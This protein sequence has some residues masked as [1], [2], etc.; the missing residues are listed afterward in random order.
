MTQ[1][2]ILVVDDEPFN[3][4]ILREYLEDNGY[5]VISAD[6]GDKALDI[7]ESNQHDFDA[8]LL[9]RMMPNMNG[10]EV[11]KTLKKSDTHK[12]LPVIMQTAAA[13]NKE[14]IQGIEAGA[15]YYLTK[16]YEPEILISIVNSAVNDYN[17]IKN[18]ASSTSTFETGSHLIETI[19]FTLQTLTEVDHVVAMLSKIIPSQ[20]RMVLGLTE[21]L[22]NAIEH[23]N[24]AIGYDLKTKLLNNK[25]WRSEI[26]K[27]LSQEMYKHKHVR[28]HCEF[29]SK[30]LKISIT[31][32]GQ[33]FDSEKYLQIDSNRLQDNHGRG[34][35]MASLVSFDKITYKG[36]GNEVYCELILT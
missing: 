2:K 30:M 5:H 15:Y 1:P 23:G 36:S 18:L 14:I 33:G 12:N 25:S 17:R 6:D 31:D 19:D 34:I 35:A 32:E 13:A 29:D 8:I 10:M 16:P 28:I 20:D 9:D 26:E 24:L 7:I 3:V 4:E 21:L 11:L 22:T 27:R